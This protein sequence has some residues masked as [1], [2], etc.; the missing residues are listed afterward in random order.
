MVCCC[1]AFELIGFFLRVAVA[2]AQKHN[3]TNFSICLNQ[4]EKNQ[5]KGLLLMIPLTEILFILFFYL[6]D[7]RRYLAQHTFDL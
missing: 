5:R 7:P 6:I 3:D 1:V 2:L 4:L